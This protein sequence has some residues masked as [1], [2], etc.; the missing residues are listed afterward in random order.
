MR[1]LITRHGTKQN[2]TSPTSYGKLN[3]YPLSVYSSIR[4]VEL[5][6]S[7]SVL[8]FN[9]TIC[10]ISSLEFRNLTLNNNQSINQSI[11]GMKKG[12]SSSYLLRIKKKLV[13]GQ[14]TW[15]FN[16]FVGPLDLKCVIW[17]LSEKLH[18]ISANIS[19]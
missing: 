19:Y 11:Y 7:N 6:R 4:I 2:K 10:K 9:W 17:A 14:Q 3:I 8:F 5:E 15:P 16:V 13:H 18:L 12:H 1:N